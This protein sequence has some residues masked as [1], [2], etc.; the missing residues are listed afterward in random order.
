MMQVM[1]NKIFFINSTEENYINKILCKHLGQIYEMCIFM[2]TP[3]K[4][5][6]NYETCHYKIHKKHLT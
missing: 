4:Y 5:I 1:C 6:L 2:D 3:K